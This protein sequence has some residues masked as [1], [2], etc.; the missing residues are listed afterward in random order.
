MTKILSAAPILDKRINELRKEC[1]SLKSQGTNPSMKVILVGDNPSSLSYI[2]NKKKLCHEVGAKFELIH[3]EES[4]SKE[5]LTSQI[6]KL[7]EDTDTHGFFV[8]FPVPAHLKEVPITTLINPNKDIDGFGPNSV[9]SLYSNTG[10]SFIPCTPKGI[11]SLLKFYNI[12]TR[13]QRVCVI[14]RSTIVGRPL[15]LLLLNKDATVTMCHSKTKDIKS[16]AQDSDIIICAIG[17]KNFIDKSFLNPQKA[18]TII[19]VGIN[20]E[21]GKLSGDCDFEQLKE[22]VHAIT[23]VP[24]GVGPLTVLSLIENLFIAAKQKDLI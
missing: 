4:T 19:D 6:K 2:K 5:E 24:G 12:E 23:P 18:Q 10:S 7:N 11:L 13:A 22:H 8:Q 17:K 16:I 15:S 3:L 14:G 1:D 20:F 21:D 9:T